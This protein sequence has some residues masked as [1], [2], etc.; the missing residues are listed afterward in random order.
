[1]GFF[2]FLDSTPEEW[3]EFLKYYQK[4][5]EDDYLRIRSNYD[6][7]LLTRKG[8]DSIKYW[9]VKSASID[10]NIYDAGRTFE[11]KLNNIEREHPKFFKKQG[12]DSSH[13][14]VADKEIYEQFKVNCQKK[15]GIRGL[16]VINAPFVRMGDRE[17]P[18]VKLVNLNA[19]ILDKWYIMVATGDGRAVLGKFQAKLAKG[20]MKYDKLLCLNHYYWNGY[21]G[22]LNDERGME[23]FE[24]HLLKPAKY[25]KQKGVLL[26]PAT[27]FY[28][29]G[30]SSERSFEQS[31]ND[32][33]FAIDAIDIASGFF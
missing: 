1:M 16:E 22:I 7:F 10:L 28:E 23:A 8:T 17:Q 33:E 32:F 15:Y 21:S 11:A 25:E 30:K 3:E 18:R 24:E 6:S 29:P 9:K 31:F 5:T 19:F 20:L 26:I 2:D 13:R 4:A 14:L 27:F 12:L